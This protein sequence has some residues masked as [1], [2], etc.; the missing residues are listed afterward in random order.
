[1]DSVYYFKVFT[2]GL[3]S[4]LLPSD[5]Q[6]AGIGDIDID[7]LDVDLKEIIKTFLHL[8]SYQFN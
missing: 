5:L 8:T 1:M 2:F 3:V 6:I 7:T 4:S